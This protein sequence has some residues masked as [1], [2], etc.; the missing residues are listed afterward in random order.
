MRLYAWRGATRNFGDELNHLL[1]PR[2]LP[3][4]LD[5][6]PACAAACGSRPGADHRFDAPRCDAPGFDDG[7]TDLFLGIGSVLDARHPA[8][9]RKIVAGAGFGG[10]QRPASLD[11]SWEIH[12]VRG[13]RTARQLG[14][15]AAFSLGDPA[16]L[17][18]LVHPVPR[19]DSGSIGFMPHF[20]SLA[21]GAWP[22]AATAAGVTLIDPRGPPLAI[23]DQIARCRALLSEALHGVI[24]ADAMRVP[25]VALMP[26]VPT[27]RAKWLDWADSLALTVR[28]QPLPASSARERV[29]TAFTP[30]RRAMR[31]GLAGAAALAERLDRRST[32][33]D[34]AVAALRRAADAPPQL[35]DCGTLCTAQERMLDRLHTLRAA[36]QAKQ[37]QGLRPWTPPGGF[38]PWTPTKGEPLE[39]FTGSG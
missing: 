24:V 32:Q 18:P 23:L 20:E 17:L 11:A 21:R 37:G 33:L 10:Y 15:P 36:R 14:L 31:T 1:W 16:S 27:H 4:L 30:R 12:W 13:P 28:F 29:E 35:S 6:A 22:A 26:L 3:G 7:G 38:A 34:R 39:P 9:R 8:D 25:W 2:L 5:I 19:R